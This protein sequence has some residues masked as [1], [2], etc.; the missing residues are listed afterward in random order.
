M[1]I[2]LAS[3]ASLLVLSVVPGSSAQQSGPLDE[4]IEDYIITGVEPA[5]PFSNSVAVCTEQICQ[6]ALLL[7]MCNV[8]SPAKLPS[9][10]TE[11]FK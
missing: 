7:P 6:L 1:S 2:V 4:D 8:F 11:P 9:S 5:C 10:T 3:L